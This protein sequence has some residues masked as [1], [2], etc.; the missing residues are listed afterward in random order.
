MSKS[1]TMKRMPIL[2]I[3]TFYKGKQRFS[4]TRADVA[5]MAANFK[6]RGNGEV[7]ID[8]EHA[9]EMPEVAAGQPV[10]AAGWIVSIDP[11]PDANHIVWG[12]ASFNARAARMI[13]AGEYKY[14]SPNLVWG[15]R[16]KTTGES[17]G[18]T[19]TSFALTNTPVLDGTS[20]IT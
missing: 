4:I 7:V 5:T 14:G 13:R 16:D 8:Y 20:G 3:G 1:Q 12:E 2:M 10:P 17:Q 9:S 15:Y 11:E 6:K 19:L 18:L